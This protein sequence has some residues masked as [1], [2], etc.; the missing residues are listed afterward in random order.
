MHRMGK[1]LG[2]IVVLAC[3]L[4]HWLAFALIASGT[5]PGLLTL[6]TSRWPWETLL[7]LPAACGVSLIAVQFR[8]R[9]A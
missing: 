2:L 9:P 6:Q 5:W 3:D 8:P 7:I 4:G 1:V